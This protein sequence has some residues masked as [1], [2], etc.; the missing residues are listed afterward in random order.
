MINEEMEGELINF[1]VLPVL[2]PSVLSVAV[3]L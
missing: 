1:L 2:R 3:W